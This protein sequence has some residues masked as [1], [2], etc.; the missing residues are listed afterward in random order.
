MRRMLCGAL[1]VGGVALLALALLPSAQAYPDG[2][3]PPEGCRCHSETPSPDVTV[4]VDGW[5]TEY[6]PGFM[7]PL[8]IAA[9]GPTAGT[10]GGFAGEVSKGTFVTSD[11][12]VTTSGKAATHKEPTKREWLVEWRA[13]PEDSGDTA[14]TVFAQQANGDGTDSDADH[15]SKLELRAKEKA[16]EPPK[17]TTMKIAF[18]AANGTLLA[19]E[20]VT[21]GVSLANFTGVP[22]PNA[23]VTFF[24]NTTWGRLALGQNK[25]GPDGVAVLNWTV[26]S[27]CECRF[28]AHYDGSARNLSVNLTT[29]ALI[30]DT[31][32]VFEA[33]YPEPSQ[34]VFDSYWGVRAPLGLVVGGV[35]GTLAYAAF[36]AVRVRA[37]GAPADDGPRGLLRLMSSRGG[38]KEEGK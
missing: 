21:I 24:Q 36:A 35:W 18:S 7:Y 38:K 5:P 37:I 17:P 11:P 6:T 26:V 23:T 19:G 1:L 28:F 3:S 33:L 22:I 30:S 27:A 34:A 9:K 32:G 25:T 10:A 4:S 2:V 8:K 14:L 29:T 15:W 20:N 13:P 12:A 16:P 31:N